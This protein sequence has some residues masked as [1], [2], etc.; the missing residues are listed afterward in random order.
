MNKPTHLFGLI[1]AMSELL[2]QIEDPYTN[3]SCI[4]EAIEQAKSALARAK[5]GIEK[6]TDKPDTKDEETL[7]SL[8]ECHFSIEHNSLCLRNKTGWLLWQGLIP[9]QP[10]TGWR[11]D[12]ITYKAKQE[13]AW[14][15]G[16]ET[17]KPKTES[18]PADKKETPFPDSQSIFDQRLRLFNVGRNLRDYAFS[19]DEVVRFGQ[20]IIK[21]SGICDNCQGSGED[22]EPP[23]ANGVGGAIF[24]CN[25]CGGTG[26]EGG[27]ILDLSDS[28]LLNV[29]K[30][31]S[32]AQTVNEKPIDLLAVAQLLDD[33]LIR[34]Y[35][36]EFLKKHRE[37]ASKRFMDGGGT[38]SRIATMA[39][40]LRKS[41]TANP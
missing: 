22:G 2:K 4:K 9:D 29:A 37:E 27:T 32:P 31:K 16:L 18:E 24:R 23:D 12:Q 35:P 39:D 26:L 1:Y 25:K 40:Q 6:D 3:G 17:N 41:V 7:D 13:I 10:K 5:N 11:W 21:L 30:Q 8:S 15:L 28:P 34:I 14:T 20:D 19:E 33:C 36:E 38:I